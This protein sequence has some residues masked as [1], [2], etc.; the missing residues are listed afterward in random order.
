M[1]LKIDYVKVYP[2]FEENCEADQIIAQVKVSRDDDVTPHIRYKKYE[3]D[4]EV[5]NYISVNDVNGNVYLTLD[6]VNTINED[7]SNPAEDIQELKFKVTAYDYEKGDSIDVDVDVKVVRVHDEP[8]KILEE[9][10]YDIYQDDAKEGHIV[11][12]IRTEF[13]AYFFVADDNIEYFHFAINDF[14]RLT[15][16]NDGVT[17]IQELN[18]DETRSIDIKIEIKDKQNAKVI[19]KTYTVPVKKGSALQYVPKKSILEQIAQYL[20]EDLAYKIRKLQLKVKDLEDIQKFLL[21]FLFDVN[22]PLLNSFDGTAIY[23]YVIGNQDKITISNT[24]YNLMSDNDIKNYLNNNIIS[25]ILKTFENLLTASQDLIVYNQESLI[26]LDK[27]QSLNLIEYFKDLNYEVNS[28]SDVYGLFQAIENQMDSR[29]QKVL[30]NILSPLIND[31]RNE[32]WSELDR[33]EEA[34]LKFKLYDSKQIFQRIMQKIFEIH[35]ILWVYSWS[36]VQDY[37][38]NRA[39]DGHGLIGKVAYNEDRIDELEK[40]LWKASTEYPYEKTTSNGLIGLVYEIDHRHLEDWG[41]LSGWNMINETNNKQIQL[42]GNTIVDASDTSKTELKGTTQACLNA[43]GTRACMRSDGTL[44]VDNGGGTVDAAVFTGTATKAKYADIAEYYEADKNYSP[45]TLL[46]IGGEKEV[47]K[48]KFNQ[49]PFIG[50][51]S[52]KPGFILNSDKEK[53]KNWVLIALRGRVKVKLEK[54]LK[55]KKGQALFASEIEDGVA[56]IKE[57]QYFIG[58]V[59]RVLDD[60]YALI[61]V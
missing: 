28:Y 17:Y 23:E 35:D 36:K 33:I 52:E 20:G 27:Y 43:G 29:I 56:G 45:G 53:F 14:G 54:N 42:G 9:F 2:I 15:M 60:D 55:V 21:N 59:L 38:S 46:M 7:H 22:G 31:I 48:F 34:F 10:V 30:D 44:I 50:V 51:V 4:E 1:G 19:Y 18:P 47:T 16:T 24:D 8:P 11:L 26:N 57:N 6:G 13:P 39:D 5:Y 32:Y 41:S 49:G 3:S 12:D 61:I 40:V 25:T 58:Y 37:A